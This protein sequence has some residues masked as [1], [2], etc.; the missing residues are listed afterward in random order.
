MAEYISGN[1]GA[2]CRVCVDT[3][4]LP[5]RYWAELAGVGRCGLSG[6]LIVPG[7]GAGVVLATILTSLELEP[8]RPLTDFDPCSGCDACVRACPGQALKGDSTL[9]CRRCLSYL[10]IEHRGPWP[11]EAPEAGERFFGC[12]ICRRV[13]PHSRN[14]ADI[15]PIEEFRPRPELMSMTAVD[16]R[17]L[18]PSRWRRL[19]R[20]RGGSPLSRKKL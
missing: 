15:E 8:D 12:D 9:D 7:V 13:C 16:F 1:L 2:L 17:D 19:S 18:T 6:Q 3:A 4:P 5:Q 10:T 20:P 11:A 14:G